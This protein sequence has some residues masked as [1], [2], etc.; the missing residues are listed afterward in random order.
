MKTKMKA[1]TVK[2]RRRRQNKTD[3]PLRL[4]LLSSN[5]LRVVIRRSLNNFTIQIV[6]FENNGDKT[7]MASHSS[8]LSAYGWKAHKGNIPAAYLS[9][10]LCGLKA[11]KEK[12][13]NLVDLGTFRAVSKTS[14][15]AVAK[16]LKDAG[17][18]VSCSDKVLP[19][20]NLVSGKSI[21]DYANSLKNNKDLYSK[22]FSK[23]IKAGIK[24]EDL[25]KHF[26][27]VKKKIE[28]KWQ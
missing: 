25:T 2:Y 24:P 12:I 9:G 17:L 14:L 20:N 21:V 26:N 10:Y 18:T 16:G 11:K 4:K 8:E 28:E 19:D 3:Y 5:K 7:V 15:F 27:E 23:Y 6:K 13:N 22:Q 1:Y